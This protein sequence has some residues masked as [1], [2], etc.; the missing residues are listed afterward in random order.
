MDWLNHPEYA[1]CENPDLVKVEL[2]GSA[3]PGLP[4]GVICASFNAG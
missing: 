1:W 2:I 4:Q 3:V